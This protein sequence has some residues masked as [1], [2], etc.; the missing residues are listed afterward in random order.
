MNHQGSP[1]CLIPRVNCGNCVGLWWHHELNGHEFEQ[2]WG[3]D[4]GQGTLVCCSPWG[5]KELDTQ[6]RDWTTTGGKDL[7]EI[8]IIS[9]TSLVTQWWRICLQCRKCRWL[10]FDP[11][12]RK[13][14]WRR[15]WQPTPVFLPGKSH[16][17]RSVVG[18]SPWG[19]KESDATERLTLS[20]YSPK[21]YLENIY[22][23]SEIQLY[24]DSPYFHLLNP[25]SILRGHV[26]KM[27]A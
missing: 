7:R 27:G 26:C 13:I 10:Q 22:Y 25:E 23:L 4:E 12:I 9:E 15:E 2:P 1:P 18:Y 3:D 16:A 6:L 19:C 8:R 24:L 20:L 21:V 5:C 17:Q 14:A 11:W